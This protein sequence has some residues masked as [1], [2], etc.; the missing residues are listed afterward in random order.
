MKKLGLAVLMVAFAILVAAAPASAAN[1]LTVNSGA[2]LNGTNFGLAVNV[3]PNI[4]DNNAV[5]VQSDHP[6]D[7]THMEIRFRLRTTTLT[8]PT[9]GPG[10]TFRFLNMVDDTA[11]ATPHKVFFLQRQPGSGAWRFV[12][13]TYTNASA[14]EFIGAFF[15]ANHGAAV[16][17]Q[18]RCEWTKATAPSNGSFRCERTDNPGSI[19]FQ[20]T[21]INDSNFQTDFV[22]AGFFDFDN[23]GAVGS[24]LGAGK[25]DFD[26]Y[27]S[28]R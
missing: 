19:F 4:G 9:T 25:V 12:A 2:A 24:P 3:G 13:W 5:Y 23:F 8:S 15:F 18:I 21:D 17:R 16:E 11:T 1:S 28:Y 14:Y 26:E 6:T 10:R 7:E 20:R 27:E 22:Q